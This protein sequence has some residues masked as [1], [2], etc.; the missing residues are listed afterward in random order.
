M[1]IDL[2]LISAALDAVL[3]QNKVARYGAI[4]LGTLLEHWESVRLRSSDLGSGIEALCRQG[5]IALEQ[6]RD[7]LWVRRRGKESGARGVYDKLLASVRG[8]V[9]G[10]ALDRIHRRRVDGYSGI[11]RRLAQRRSARDSAKSMNDSRRA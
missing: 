7:G 2:E 6:R 1:K 11:D 9:V 5:R 3:K 4:P 8:M 10:L